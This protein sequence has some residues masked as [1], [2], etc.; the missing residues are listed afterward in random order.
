MVKSNAL[1]AI[2][3]VLYRFKKDTG[4]PQLAFG[5]QCNLP[6]NALTH[7]RGKRC[8][9]KQSGHK[10]SVLPYAKYDCLKRDE[11]KRTDGTSREKMQPSTAV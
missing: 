3:L 8:A 11:T 7:T 5:Q 6:A 10:G 4:T 1:N 2:L 9:H